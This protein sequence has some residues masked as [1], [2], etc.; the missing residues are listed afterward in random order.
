MTEG[1]KTFLGLAVPLLGESEIQAQSATA[2]ILTITHSTG[3]S[4][5]FIVAQ[6]YTGT[7]V[8]V[9]SSSGQVTARGLA[10]TGV[11]TVTNG[12]LDYTI[13][14]TTSTNYGISFTLGASAVAD[15]LIKYTAGITG[16]TTSV[17]QVSS[18]NGP[19]YLLSVAT[20]ASSIDRT[21]KRYWS[22]A[23]IPK[24]LSGSSCRPI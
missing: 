20:S 3:G 13:S 2:D 16:A 23:Y 8:F 12:K 19:T 10:L 7:E 24:F 6:G 15:A 21:T 17:F 14:S 1:T 18:T 4:G 11:S 9:V 22:C 5:D